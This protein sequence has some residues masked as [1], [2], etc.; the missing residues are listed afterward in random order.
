MKHFI[1]QA[2]LNETSIQYLT[3]K[4]NEVIRVVNNKP[5]VHDLEYWSD[6]LDQFKNDKSINTYT[7]LI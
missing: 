6:V 2:S 4:L 7:D 5:D 3:Y 1:D